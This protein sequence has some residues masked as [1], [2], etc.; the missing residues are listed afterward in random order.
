MKGGVTSG[1]VYPP[2]VI[3]LSEEYRFR[4]I[5]GTSAGAIAAAAT[6]AAEYGRERRGF[7]KL[8]EI[9][10][11]LSEG[12]FLEGLF[13]PSNE[14][15]PLLDTL[16]AMQKASADAKAVDVKH[17]RSGVLQKM[18]VLGGALH[19]IQKVWMLSGVLKH[20]DKDAFRKG[21]LVGGLI[22]VVLA[23]SLAALAFFVFWLTE[24][25]ESLRGL[26]TL[27]V[28]ISLLLCF[29]GY[30]LGGI[31]GSGR[32][33]YQVL[34]V[35]VPENFF[36]LCSGRRVAAD[37]RKEALTD[38]LSIQI[39]DL[40]GIADEQRPLTFGTLKQKGITLRMMTSNL[41]Q[42][43]P[44]VIPF[45]NIRFIFSRDEFD[46]LFPEYIL[47]HL[48]KKA[49]QS[50]RVTLP[51]GYYFLPLTEDLP[52]ALALRLSL[53][54]PLLISAVPLY[55]IS[56][57]AFARSNQGEKL[58]LNENDLMLNWFSDGGISSN[59]PIQFF[60]VWLPKRPTFGIK[61]EAMPP[62]ALR[63][64]GG[65]Q[66]HV[67]PEYISVAAEGGESSDGEEIVDLKAAAVPSITPD[68][69]EIYDAVY[70]PKAN[71]P[72][73]TKW[74]PMTKEPTP[75]GKG[76]PLSLTKFVWSIFETAQNYRDNMQ[77]ALSSYRER[78]VQ[79]R[80]RDDEGGLNLM[81]PGEVIDNVIKKGLLAG[82]TILTHFNFEHHQWVRFRVLMAQLEENLMEMK[83]V[84]RDD[85]P[86]FDLRKLMSDQLNKENR[87][88][89][90]RDESWSKNAL[91]RIEQ[92]HNVVV[93]WE[94]PVFGQGIPRPEPV[95][96]ITPEI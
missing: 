75:T 64:S 7:A 52:V 48:I 89:Y 71:A 12:G 6:A 1:I 49:Y 47:D 26:L 61:L 56:L 66:H 19:N 96:R 18:R 37:V 83:E 5:G 24:G 93:E 60:D 14:T 81:M 25:Q 74:L 67:E 50:S 33:L 38:W 76:A 36:G 70:L 13:Q 88:P 69:D 31:V 62:E 82:E 91:E 55:R 65:E 90:P 45:E 73:V 77:S 23:L 30:R 11:K 20:N 87:Y 86:S 57:S 28:V 32:H 10:K 27:F 16:K 21:A 9:R 22:S 63:E 17:N 35:K 72:L 46:K 8:D 43:Q 54:F 85:N 4:A 40:A 79:I 39:D 2:V 78:V 44:Y 68:N 53:S 92:L 42:N 41:S 29:T 84:L 94:R 51:T 95:L 59:F 15:R 3:K 34:T 80:L 58:Q